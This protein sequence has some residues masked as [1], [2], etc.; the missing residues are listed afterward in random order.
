MGFQWNPLV[1]EHSH[2]SHGPFGDG[3]PIKNGDFSWLC[4]FINLNWKQIFQPLGRVYVNKNWS[5]TDFTGIPH[6]MLWDFVVMIRGS[7]QETGD[8]LM[9][10]ETSMEHMVIYNENRIE[11]DISL[12]GLNMGPIKLNGDIL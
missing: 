2:G 12:M 8:S 5:V 3:L 9:E 1:I 10:R 11:I 4:K 6:G 7:H